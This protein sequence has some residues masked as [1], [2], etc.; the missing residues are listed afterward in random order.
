MKTILIIGSIFIAFLFLTT[1]KALAPPVAQHLIDAKPPEAQ[2]FD[3]EKWFQDHP[4]EKGGIRSE[5]VFL[6]PRAQVNFLRIKGSPLGRHI[7]SQVDEIVY[8]YK[9]RG[10]MYINGKW[11]PVKAGQFHTCPRGVAHSTRTTGD[12]EIW[13]IAFFTDP[14]PPLGD[15][16]MVDE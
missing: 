4:I 12:E 7:H 5:T 14:L 9:G 3:A 13:L 11:V 15:R 10:E 2:L 16:V 1:G 8:I 6:S